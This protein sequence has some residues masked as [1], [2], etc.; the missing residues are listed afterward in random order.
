[1]YCIKC[2]S[3][4]PDDIAFCTKCGAKLEP[5]SNETTQMAPDGEKKRH[6]KGLII[7]LLFIIALLI[8][9]IVLIIRFVLMSS[10]AD[11]SPSYETNTVSS[12]EPPSNITEDSKNNLPSYS[13]SS[14]ASS[15]SLESEEESALSSA[16]ITPVAGN[17]SNDDFGLN[18]STEENYYNIV[19]T[20]TYKYYESSEN[21][22][23][24]FWYPIGLYNKVYKDTSI[25]DTNYGQNIEVVNFTGSAGSTAKFS[26]IERVDGDSL[27]DMATYV[28]NQEF[29]GLDDPGDIYPLKTDDE[30][31]FFIVTGHSPDNYSDLAYD[32][33]RV[34]DSYVYQ[35]YIVFPDFEDDT[36]KNLKS[37][38]TECL[39]RTCGFS[40]SSRDVRSYSDYLSENNDASE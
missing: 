26:L 22:R 14:P 9:C 17:S 34:D 18:E 29:S 21:S 25:S 15:S 7:T 39:Y 8:I 40:N 2:G 11:A 24:N 1:M 33:V 10:E 16:S 35:M 27:D 38:F 12:Q 31:G 23:F 3:K 6:R 20:D 19:D 36:D 28:Y 37:Y 13:S 5:A 32:M 4:M 30:K